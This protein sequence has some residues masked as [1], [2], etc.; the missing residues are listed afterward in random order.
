MS[1]TW[2]QALTLIRD[3]TGLGFERGEYDGAWVA[4]VVVVQ[5]G[6]L[7]VVAVVVGGSGLHSI[8]AVVAGTVGV[9]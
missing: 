5:Y 8:R 1:L 4:V 3:L 6:G 2:H 7:C 9:G